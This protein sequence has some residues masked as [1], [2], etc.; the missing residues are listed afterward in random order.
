[1][2]KKL[3]FISCMNLELI[4]NVNSGFMKNLELFRDETIPVCKFEKPILVCGEL[5]S[6]NSV[7]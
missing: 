7:K 2:E 4:E 1:M 6:S 3:D 5:I